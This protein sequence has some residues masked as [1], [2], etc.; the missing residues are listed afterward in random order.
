M[1]PEVNKPT[2]IGKTREEMLSRFF[3]NLDISGKQL[4][5]WSQTVLRQ[6]GDF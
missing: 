6:K 5:K 3:E 4:D 2:R 1:K